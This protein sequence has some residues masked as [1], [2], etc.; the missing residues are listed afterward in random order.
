VG[1]TRRQG[2]KK[3]AGGLTRQVRGKNMPLHGNVL[4]APSSHENG[5]PQVHR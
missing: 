1:K 4:P 5:L 2:K 3:A